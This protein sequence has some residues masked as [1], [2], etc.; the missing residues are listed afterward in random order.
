MQLNNHSLPRFRRLYERPPDPKKKRKRPPRWRHRLSF[1]ELIRSPLT[2][3]LALWGV[4]I[5]F[6]VVGIRWLLTPAPMGPE[7]Y[8]PGKRAEVL[9]KR[10]QKNQKTRIERIFEGVQVQERLNG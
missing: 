4:L 7:K 2:V 10:N 5:G 1:G 3:R 8:V 9:Q 6:F